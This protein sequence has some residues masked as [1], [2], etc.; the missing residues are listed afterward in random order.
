MHTSLKLFRFY[1]VFPEADEILKP[2]KKFFI[3]F[4]LMALLSSLTLIGSSTHLIKAIKDDSY[5]HLELDLTYILSM[6]AS[7]GMI[8]YYIAKMSTVV[9]LYLFF[10]EF[11]ELGKPADFDEINQK[12]GKYSKYH[13]CYLES[14][15]MTILLGSNIFK[16][17]QC[18]SENEMKGLH[19]V[20]G[21]FSYTW[22]PFNIDYFPVK[23]IYLIIQLFGVHYIYMVAGQGAWIFLETTEHILVRIRHV[24]YL[25]DEAIKELDPKERRQKFNFAVRN[26]I[27]V[28]GLEKKLNDLYSVFMFTHIVMTSFIM[29]FGVYA[30]MKDRNISSFILS[31]AW[32]IGLFMDSHSGQR[33]QDESLAVGT[34]LYNADWSH[35]E[36]QLKKDIM[37][38]LMRC[39]QPLVF[40]ADPFGNMD[41]CIFLAVVKASYSYLTIL[42][43]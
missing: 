29:G 37:F 14:L 10:S 19:E 27:A 22:M 33:I 40:K 23:Q 2:G 24:A 17:K 26:H 9:E 43:R 6:T 12:F 21:L 20:C 25:F 7:Y 11:E 15:M 34:T 16:G 36:K 30:Y 32:F 3:K 41:H 18:R 35:C 28:L 39:Q 42:S 4:A 5:N 1:G 31:F 8:C 13:Y 38:V